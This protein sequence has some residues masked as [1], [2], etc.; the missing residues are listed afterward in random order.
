MK[1][2]FTLL[3]C[4]FVAAV[5]LAQ[6]FPDSGISEEEKSFLGLNDQLAKA[7]ENLKKQMPCGFPD[8]GIP[9]LA[10][11]KRPYTEIQY[12]HALF[13]ILANFF[14]LRV[15]GLN[16]YRTNAVT[17]S[18]LTMKGTFDLNFNM[19]AAKGQYK[20]NFFPINLIR[21]KGEG[22]LDFK[23][24]DLRVKGDFQ[25]GIKGKGTTLKSFN[26]GVVLGDVNSNISNLLGGGLAGRLANRAIE[27]FVKFFIKTQHRFV[28]DTLR[29]KIVTIVNDKLQNYTVKDLL[30]I[31][32]AS[33]KPPTCVPPPDNEINL[34]LKLL[35]LTELH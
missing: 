5:A 8:H 30:D 32:A 19:I 2:R 17:M 15:D 14:D 6:D 16:D 7:L 29:K 21:I 26:I 10:P 12:N 28:S 27:N 23:L 25:L 13:S 22:D 34:L 11:F 4:C 20:M 33:Q 35:Q 9:P 1:L 3:L 18:I 24:K 31:I